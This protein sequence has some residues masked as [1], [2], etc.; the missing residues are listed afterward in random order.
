MMNTFIF[1]KKKSSEYGIY[2]S[3]SGTYNFPERDITTYEVP[4]RN[5]DLIVDNG[6]FK[7]I[8]LKYP[9]FI[10]QKFKEN[11]D[12]ARMWLLK[13]STYHRLE[14]SYHPD[15]F[16]MARFSG[17]LD[18]KTRFLN[19]S[20]ECDLIFDCKPQRF[21]KSGEIPIVSEENIVV[22]NPTPF[23]ATPLIR[24]YGTGGELIVGNNIIQ[25]KNIDNYVD[26]DC[27]TQ[28]AF[29]GTVNCN[30][31][32]VLDT[33]PILPEGETGVVFNGDITKIEIIPRWWLA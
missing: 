33:F 16:R 21:L 1:N 18:W 10:R 23:E 27:D 25:I 4:G 9:A 22:S 19:Y 3:G 11:T 28:N 32:I 6:R 15:I 12:G 17:P 5:G 24:V 31:N 30:G 8:L 2:I 7:N 20:G 14:D 13:S 26:I 29:K